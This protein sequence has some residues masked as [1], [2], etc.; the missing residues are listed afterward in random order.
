MIEHNLLISC[1]LIGLVGSSHCIGMCGGLVSAFHFSLPK[2]YQ[3][4]TRLFIYQSLYNSGRICSYIFMGLVV[5]SMSA[6]VTHSF[7]FQA[8]L[9]LRLFASVM[10]FMLGL[11]LLGLWQIISKLEKIGFYLWKYISPFSKK[12]MPVNHPFKAFGLGVIWGWLPCG[13][14]YST[15]TL[16]FSSGNSLQGGLAM[17]CFGLGTMP[18]MLFAGAS[19]P[20]LKSVLGHSFFRKV[21]GTSMVLFGALMLGQ[22]MLLNTGSTCH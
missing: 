10:L 16:A 19:I 22:S 12:L 7:G 6:K 11:Y 2:S 3:T 21:M 15:L 8:L 20:L 9:Y 14:I 18:A 1:F 5:G 17:L 13:L 4:P